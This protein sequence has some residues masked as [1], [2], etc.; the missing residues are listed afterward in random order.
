ME[1]I[2][3]AGGMGTR[4]RSV[5][6]DLPKCMA[7]VAGQPFIFYLFNYL[8]RNNVK[9]IILSLGYKHE[10][11]K[12]WI[13]QQ[14]FPFNFAYSIEDEPLGTGGAIKK[15]IELVE[16]EDVFI[17]NGDTLFEIDLRV[18]KDIHKK[19]NLPLSLALKPMTE[20]ERYGNVE[21]ND[22]HIIT[23]F[24]E[25]IY[26]KEGMIN[27]GIYL[28]KKEN[29]LMDN[30]SKKF[31]FETKILQ[32]QAGQGIIQGYINTGYFIDIGI[33]LDYEKANKEFKRMFK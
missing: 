29:H 1:A 11:V 9:K 21:I 10:V 6:S 30:L 7:P 31:S 26:C 13:E 33:P 24:K 23:G 4:I 20:F 17:L 2:I 28:L 12:E 27:G 18:F 15:S 22:K 32:Q 8:Q 3:L 25:K 16:S 5:V 19:S 14:N